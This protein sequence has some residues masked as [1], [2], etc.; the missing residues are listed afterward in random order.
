MM[1]NAVIIIE[2][3]N[4]PYVRKKV[5]IPAIPPLGAFSPNEGRYGV[6]DHIWLASVSGKF[7]YEISI[8]VTK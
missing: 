6:V 5:K 7:L 2:D 8:D 1:I 4:D 3:G